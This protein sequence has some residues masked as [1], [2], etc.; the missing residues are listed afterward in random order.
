M[1]S[2]TFVSLVVSLEDAFDFEFPDDKLIMSEANT[3]SGLKD[4]IVS[5]R[6]NNGE[7]GL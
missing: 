5:T 6:Q 3:I 4:I 7:G 1:D 2:I